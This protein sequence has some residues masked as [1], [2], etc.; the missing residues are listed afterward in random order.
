MARRLVQRIHGDLV[1]TVWTGFDQ[2]RSLGEGE[3]GGHVSVPIWTYFMHEALAGARKHGPPVPDGIVTVR[4]SPDTGML[5]SADNPNGSWKS[6]STA[7]FPRRRATRAQQSER[8]DGWRQAA[9]LGTPQQ[10][11]AQVGPCQEFSHRAEDL[12]RALAQEAAR[13]MAEHGNRDFLQAKRKAADR[14]GGTTYPCCR[15]MSRSRTPCA[16]T[17]ACSGAI[18]MITC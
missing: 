9:L 1:A 7:A 5:A 13:I 6:S 3:E 12:R 14:L 2:E 17:S 18:P 10:D 8:D 11:H 15:R 4:I 16:S